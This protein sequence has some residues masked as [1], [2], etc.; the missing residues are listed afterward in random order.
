MIAIDVAHAAPGLREALPLLHKG[1]KAMLWLPP[2]DGMADAIAYDVELVDV[3]P[4]PAA[5]TPASTA[6]GR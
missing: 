2:G 6:A 1:E 3:V 5:D 4:R